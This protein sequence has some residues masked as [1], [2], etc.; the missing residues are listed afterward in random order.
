MYVFC[1]FDYALKIKLRHCLTL[2][3]KPVRTFLRWKGWHM[4]AFEIWIF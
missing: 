1:S 2:H 4:P 3:V